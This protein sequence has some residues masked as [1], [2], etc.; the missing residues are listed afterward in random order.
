MPAWPSLAGR[1]C[2]TYYPRR[3]E[4]GTNRFGSWPAIASW[5]AHLAAERRQAT[6]E[7]RQK[8][9]E[10]TAGTTTPL[11]KIRALAAFVQSDIRYVAI[12]IGIGGYQPHPAADIFT[13][14][15][16]DCKDK[17]TL[18]ATMLAV[19][20]IK[21]YYVLMNASRGVVVPESPSALD[22]DHV[23][24]AIQFPDVRPD[25]IVWAVQEVPELGKLLFF[26]PTDTLVPFGFLPDSLQGN[27]GL[28]VTDAGGQLVKLRL[29]PAAANRLLRNAKLTLTPDGTLSG[30]VIELRWGT[31]AV[32]L[33][34]RLLR[35]SQADRQKVLEAFLGQFLG[36]SVLQ[37]VGMQNLENFNRP[38]TL[39][40]TFAATDFAKLSGDLFMV[41]PRVLGS[42]GEDVLD[43]KERKNPVEFAASTSQGDLFEITLPDGYTADELPEPVELSTGETS[44]KS[45]AEMNGN[46]L[47]YTRLYQIT[48]IRVPAE[49]LKHLQE[50]Y[51]Q[52][53]MDERS[54]AIFKK[55]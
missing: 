12:E 42:K 14:R 30:T 43:A 45:K 20:G 27:Y 34:A 1:L 23:I 8:V 41:R 35:A 4:G 2:V 48:D 53:A 22:F 5:Y 13:N 36:G 15:Y 10:L 28:V 16:G 38:L 3:T 21:S 7:I 50:F 17:A 44:Y 54:I 9:T 40:Y 25:S 46:V 24:L 6:P 47:H 19:A 33:R 26:D 37:A 55:R 32:E 11:D 39:Q 31:P 18:L 29:L 49:Q 51:R 52:V